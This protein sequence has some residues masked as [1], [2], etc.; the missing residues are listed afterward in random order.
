M[1]YNKNVLEIKKDIENH[2]YIRDLAT[3]YR[4][5]DE[6]IARSLYYHLCMKFTYLSLTKI[7]ATLGR[8][9]ATVIHANTEFPFILPYY[10]DVQILMKKL[11]AKYIN[12]GYNLSVKKDIE[13]VYCNLVKNEIETNN[14][15]YS[16]Y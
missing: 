1:K 9:H 11:T 8:T 10:P 15:N 14:A 12:E 6:I 13:V 2:L 16:T 7:G 3:K 4:G 5:R